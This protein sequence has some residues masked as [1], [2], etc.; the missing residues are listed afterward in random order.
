MAMLAENLLQQKKKGQIS[1]KF[2]AAKKL[3]KLA[4][5][6]LQQNNGQVSRKFT[7]AKQ[8]SS[9]QKICCSEKC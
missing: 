4:E 2:A 8:W 9:Q 1:R 5:N 7:A 3:V 6:L